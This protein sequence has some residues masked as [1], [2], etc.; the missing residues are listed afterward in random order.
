MNSFRRGAFQSNASVTSMIQRFSDIS[1]I[2]LGLYISCFI[3][4]EHFYVQHWLMILVSI[5]IF[6][7]LGGMSDFYRSWRGVRVIAELQLILKNWSLS[8][9][10]TFGVIAFVRG[11]E[12]DFA[13]YLQ[14]YLL[15]CIGL[16][17]SRG[18]IRL[19]LR[20]MRNLGYNTRNVAIM[21]SMP[22]GIRLAETLRDTPW[23]G[24]KVLGFYDDNVR[25]NIGSI[26]RCGDLEQ[27]IKD[28][29]S[30]RIDRIYIAMPMEREATIKNMVS[31]LSDSTCSVMLIPDIFTFNMLQSRNEE[32]NGIPVLSL[33]DTPMSGINRIVKRFED[34]ILSTIILLFISPI[35][36]IIALMVKFTS[37]GPVIFKQ[38]RYG[39]DGKPIAV[40]KFR[41]MSVM[42]NGS[43][44]VQAKKGDVR[45]TRIGAFLRST[46]LDELPQFFN[47]IT[48]DM[49]IVGPRPH[50]V[51]HNEQY[52]KLIK[53][54]ML[55]HKMKPGI[56]GWAQ[57][58]GWRGE[59]DTLDKMQRR[60]EF[61][62]DYISNWS[63]WF[64]LKI[65]FLTIFKGFVNK[66]AY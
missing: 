38:K 10:L 65:I 27:L 5:V 44:V 32:I 18:A 36:L 15:V 19:F 64:D 39:M 35:L 60:V 8:L 9:L 55:R 40:W 58:N 62:L 63:V 50:A 12:D 13:I 17:S 41:S 2:F 23:M 1:I 57:I 24:F 42:E 7:M 52:R 43:E 16:S 4:G 33:F 30:G 45:L 37:R 54:Y 47:V 34:I 53:G 20:H 31:E 48:G 26:S 14:W 46:S 49:S 29:K 22:I 6:Q 56:T 11:F 51:Y 66:S 3:L 59:T 25:D 21:G 28:S 61:D